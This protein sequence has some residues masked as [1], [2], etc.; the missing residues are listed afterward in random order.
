MIALDRVGHFFLEPKEII[1]L[2]EHRSDPAHLEHQPLDH[3]VALAQ[4]RRPQLAGFFR[5][6]H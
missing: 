1:C 5:Q 3:Q 4:I 2:A 6:I